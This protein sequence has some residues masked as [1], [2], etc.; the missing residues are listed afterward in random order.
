[1]GYRDHY[2]VDG[3]K[4]RI[5][6]SALVSPASIMDNTPLL[7]LIDWTCSR[8][9]LE[10][11]IAVGDAKYG[12]VSNIVGLEERGIKAYLST[13]DL[14]KRSE[15]Y[16]SDQFQYYIVNDQYSCPQNHVLPLR[17]RCKS[18]EKFVYR[19]DAKVFDACPV[20]IEC[21]GSKSGQSIFRYFH[22]EY[23]EKV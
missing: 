15:Y 14:S 3:G 22:Q 11:K 8:W 20:K 7:D 17:S 13:S 1:M 16:S 19:A 18:E 23:I 4:S 6:L 5:I 9:S 2:I 10:P 21:T 12:T